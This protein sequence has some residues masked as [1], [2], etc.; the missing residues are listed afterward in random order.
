M[1]WRLPGFKLFISGAGFLLDSNRAPR[2]YQEARGL[3]AKNAWQVIPDM[4]LVSSKSYRI[5]LLIFHDIPWF[6]E[7]DE[8]IVW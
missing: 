3:P 6:P 1:E 7:L 5:F 4:F 8:G 2:W